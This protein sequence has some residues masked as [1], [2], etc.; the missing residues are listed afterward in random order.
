MSP[1]KTTVASPSEKS[2]I[3]RTRPSVD[4]SFHVLL[5]GGAAQGMSRQVLA[6]I[7]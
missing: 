6:S 5:I 2:L 7:S 4:V 3:V 1:F